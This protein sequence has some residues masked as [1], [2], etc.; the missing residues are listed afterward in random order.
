MQIRRLTVRFFVFDQDDIFNGLKSMSR[1]LKSADLEIGDSAVISMTLNR[2]A[3]MSVTD[4]HDH[5]SIAVVHLEPLMFHLTT[6]FESR[7][8]LME[9]LKDTHAFVRSRMKSDGFIAGTWG[10]V[11]S[12]VN[13]APS[14]VW[15]LT[16]VEVQEPRSSLFQH[17]S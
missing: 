12:M 16:R 14:G 3:R 17:L 11:P 4:H 6:M 10:D 13:S 1:A 7:E 2:A 5:S 8:E 15:E 9:L